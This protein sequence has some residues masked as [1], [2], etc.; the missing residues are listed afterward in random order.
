MQIRLIPINKLKVM[1]E[2]NVYL[3]KFKKQKKKQIR[4]LNITDQI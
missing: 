3:M 4:A 2:Y 1:L